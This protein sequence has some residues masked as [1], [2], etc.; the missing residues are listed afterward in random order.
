MNDRV[1]V[2]RRPNGIVTLTLNR[3]EKR[4]A[5]DFP[6]L[7]ALTRSVHHEGASASVLIL[8]GAGHDAFS[9][10][11]D[12]DALTGTSEDLEADAAVGRAAEALR[13]CPVPVIAR[14]EGHCHGAAV[15]LA[16][17]CDLR[18][19]ADTFKFSLKAVDLGVVYRTELLARLTA[20]TG[21]TRAEHLLFAMPVLDAPDALSWGLV[22]EIVPAIQIGQRIDA[23]ADA[24]AN[25]PR[26]AVVGT[27]ATFALF[28]TDEQ[29]LEAAA[30]WRSAAASS[31]ERSTALAAA[32][33]RL[34]RPPQRSP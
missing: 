23:I 8:R 31:E 1:Q 4:N 11:F 30:P 5:L 28:V 20:I 27:K 3:P 29:Q 12:L 10:G 21:L 33:T 34:K 6:L 15:D 14:L 25:A 24:L 22:G 32:R 18:I 13:T 16:L 7:D 19:A 2:G 26:S 9:A 17:H